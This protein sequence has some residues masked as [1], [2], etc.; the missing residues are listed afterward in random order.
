MNKLYIFCGIPFAGKT[1]LAKQVVSQLGYTRID[2]DETKFSLFGNDVKDATINKAGWNQVYEAMYEQ[3]ANA[4]QAGQSVIND[5]GNFTLPERNE[6]RAIGEKLGIEVVT[7]FI[8]TPADI[9]WQ[10][11]QSNRQHPSRFDVTDADFESAV[12]EMAQPS[13]TEKHLVYDGRTEP[14]RWIADSLT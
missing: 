9:A 14:K 3:I 10:R 4:L 11:M 5:A 6:V 12:E 2:L 8:D 1:E 7:V 13:D